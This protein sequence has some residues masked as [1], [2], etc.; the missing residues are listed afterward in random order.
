MKRVQIADRLQLY[1]LLRSY[2]TGIRIFIFRESNSN[3]YQLSALFLGI[4]V[5]CVISSIGNGA[6][7]FELW[8][9]LVT[10]DTHNLQTWAAI[11]CVN[12]FKLCT[13]IMNALFLSKGKLSMILLNWWQKHLLLILKEKSSG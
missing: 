10:W 6:V 13:T 2:K 12:E 5:K 9:Y 7:N 3:I 4:K 11:L 8:S 1:V